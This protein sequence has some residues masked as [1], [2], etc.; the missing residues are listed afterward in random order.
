MADGQ[1]KDLIIVGGG[2]AGITAAVYA[3]RKKI[4]FAIIT[5]D[6]GGQAAWSGGIENY[7]GYQFVTGPELISKFQQHLESYGFK[8]LDGIEVS[9]V[10]KVAGMGPGQ[11]D[12]FQVTTF[13]GDQYLA[14]A[15]IVATGKRPKLL[16]VPGEAEYKNKGVAYCVTCD[17]PIFK[18]KIVAVVGG[19]NSALDAVLQMI[20]YASKVYLINLTDSLFGDS[21]MQEKVLASDKVEVLYGAKTLSISGDRFVRSIKIEQKGQA[22]DLPVAGVFVEI[23]LVPN[24]DFIDCV[25]KN[26]NGE[27][28]INCAAETSCSGVFAAGDVTA[29]P[30]KQVIIA[31]GDGAKAALAAFRY[32]IS[33]KS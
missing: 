20:R 15:V 3:A 2:P 25:E 11:P 28:I 8:M 1:I 24:S 18:D 26:K 29:V 16:N 7:T 23:G 19:G 31:A 13:A 10:A 32:L 30:S 12:R 4:D 27:I 9:R 33:H 14:R 22:R 17:G 21:V 5:Q 6:I